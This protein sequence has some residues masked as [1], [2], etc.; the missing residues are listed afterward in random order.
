MSTLSDIAGAAVGLTPAVWTVLAVRLKRAANT[1]GAPGAVVRGAQG[2]IAAGTPAAGK[3][4]TGKAPAMSL[5]VDKGLFSG[6]EQAAQVETALRTLADHAKGYGTAAFAD[7]EP[8]APLIGAVVF[9]TGQ[10]FE[11]LT[12]KGTAQQVRMAESRYAD[13]LA[14]VTRLNAPEYLGDIL[15]HPELWENADQR[16]VTVRSVLDGVVNQIIT[17][18]RQVNT[19]TDLDFQVA[20][21]ALDALGA[22]EEFSALHTSLAAGSAPVAASVTAGAPTA[23]G[24]HAVDGD[25]EDDDHHER[26]A[27]WLLG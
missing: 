1:V 26:A 2:A 3:P 10:L 20:K 16:L 4:A 7:G 21:A 5:K 22:E 17:N 14:K 8:V 12:G 6:S 11:R 9:R 25:D 15:A 23:A 18:I 24:A 27:G 13:I 19:S